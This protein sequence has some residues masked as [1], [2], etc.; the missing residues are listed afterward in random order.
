MMDLNFAAMA[1]SAGI[2]S[3]LLTGLTVVV[4]IAF[5]AAVF[6]DARVIRDNREALVFVGPVIWSV[7]VLVGG[8]LI[9]A[10][11]WLVHHSALRRG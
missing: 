4:H 5:S 7:A 6:N 9:G 3:F 8:V 2:W 1:T 11:Y 10:A